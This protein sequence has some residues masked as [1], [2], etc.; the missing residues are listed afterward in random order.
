MSAKKFQMLPTPPSSQRSSRAERRKLNSSEESTASSQST[1]SITI[2]ITASE[3]RLGIPAPMRALPLRTASV[4]QKSPVSVAYQSI[5]YD[6][7]WILGELEI[8]YSTLSLVQRWEPGQSPTAADVTIL[9]MADQSPHWQAALNEIQTL[10][11]KK[12]LP[13]MRLEIMNEKAHLNFYL[14]TSNADFKKDWD[15][16]LK[17]RVLST[18][19]TAGQ[20]RSLTILNRGHTRNT[21]VPT[22]T[23]ELTEMADHLWQ[24]V[25]YQNILEMLEDFPGVVDKHIAFVRP[26]GLTTLGRNPPPTALPIGAFSGPVP[27]GSSIGVGSSTGTIG[28]YVDVS[29]QGKV[30]TMGLTNHHVVENDSMTAGKLLY[31]M[32]LTLSMGLTSSVDEKA[33][34]LRPDFTR[35]HIVKAPSQA[36]TDASIQ[37]FE[38]N[39]AS[40]RDQLYGPLVD[41]DDPHGSRRAESGL[42]F[43]VQYS[44]PDDTLEAHYRTAKAKEATCGDRINQVNNADITFGS[45]FATSGLS[46]YY[47]TLQPHQLPLGK[48]S[49][50]TGNAIDWALINVTNRARIGGNLIPQDLTFGGDD[51][52][53]ALGQTIG[54]AQLA[55]VE[56]GTKLFKK[57]RNGTCVGVVSRFEVEIMLEG[58]RYRAAVV[59][60]TNVGPFLFNG[61]SGCFCF[62]ERGTFC[63]LGFAGCEESGAGYVLPTS[64]IY[65]DIL[66]RTGAE[67]VNPRLL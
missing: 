29:F 65:D 51:T 21:A 20:W 58:R 63:A 27:M 8:N 50:K 17:A 56:P 9:I 41:Q 59:M 64:W 31:A 28:G 33:N 32:I 52:C 1:G 23:I 10:I 55:E 30:H 49:V 66:A 40:H 38:N 43:K 54:S 53:L 12:R 6:V 62:N 5:K 11:I 37:S 36:D 46:R 14:P 18:L 25:V 13:F 22:V 35:M 7:H 57:G 3:F 42:E 60:P 44:S 4:D 45:I 48:T 26:S 2:D 47:G 67:I 24:Q 34:G 15:S 16:S 39:R 61:D 19:G